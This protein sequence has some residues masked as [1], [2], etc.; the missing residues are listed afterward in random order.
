MNSDIH[1]VL[2]GS[3]DLHVHSGPDRFPRAFDDLELLGA[4][5]SAG[6][7]GAVVKSHFEG[8]SSRA[9]LANR[10]LPGE[11][12]L[13]GSVTLNH[14]VGGLNPA[15][16]DNEIRLGGKII[17]LPTV[18]AAN[19]L[20]SP[21]G[22]K[23]AGSVSGEGITLLTPDGRLKDEVLDILDFAMEG[24]VALATGHAGPAEA[25]AVCREGVRRGLERMILTHPDWGGILLPLE[26]QIELGRGGVFIEKTL[27]SLDC[28]DMEPL[29]LAADI[30]AVGVSRCILTTDYGK[31][32]HASIP[33]GLGRMLF[34]LL[35]QGFTP[36]ELDILVRKNPEQILNLA[37]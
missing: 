1:E 35:E 34:M 22:L 31:A 5:Q 37:K 17:W 26:I 15:A 11:G 6:M 10:A 24:G 28:G 27:L 21:R 23:S 18:D 3:F 29:R 16:A 19:N 13:Y 32:G 8:T 36:D 30:R 2:R 25:A 20:S 7:G 12:R 14:S 33:E 4:L 9:F